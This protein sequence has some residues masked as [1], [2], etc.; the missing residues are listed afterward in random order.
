MQHVATGRCL[1]F[2]PGEWAGDVDVLGKEDVVPCGH[3]LL[4]RQASVGGLKAGAKFRVTQVQL[5]MLEL[6]PECC[7]VSQVRFKLRQL[8]RPERVCDDWWVVELRHS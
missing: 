3:I 1:V 4:S 6:A 7:P 2:W 5:R 8:G